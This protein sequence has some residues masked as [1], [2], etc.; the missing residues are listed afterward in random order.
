MTSK[1][2]K[3]IIV[4]VFLAVAIVI[5]YG[6][7]Q[8][9][10][11]TRIDIYE[12]QITLLDFRLSDAEN[13]VSLLKEENEQLTSRLQEQV[14]DKMKIKS[15]Y[16]ILKAT[17]DE[18]A[19]KQNKTSAIIKQLSFD[20]VFLQKRLNQHTVITYSIEDEAALWLDIRSAAADLD[21]ELVPMVDLLIKDYQDLYSWIE[22]HS[23]GPIPIEEA[24]LIMYEGYNILWKLLHEDLRN[25]DAHW[26][27]IIEQHMDELE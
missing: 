21:P 20:R 23:E 2:F 13:Q 22:E 10:N 11:Q 25:F 24:G 14:E 7:T 27:E 18:L 19:D 9:A 16:E 17:Y 1:T 4:V 6:L 8:L 15:D 12:E 5:T 26:I 3:S